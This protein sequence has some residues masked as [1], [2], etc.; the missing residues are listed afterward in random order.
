[1]DEL[2]RI[3]EEHTRVVQSITGGRVVEAID[4]TP[5]PLLRELNKLL[6]R[7]AVYGERS[8]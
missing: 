6:A 4:L 5:G 3:F 2:K 8:L 7:Y 1:M